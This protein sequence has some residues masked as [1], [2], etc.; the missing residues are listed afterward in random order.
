MNK[1][2]Q[3]F[4]IMLPQ[5]HNKQVITFGNIEIENRKSDCHKYPTAAV[6]IYKMLTSNRVS[7]SEKK[8][9]HFIGY[10]DDYCKI[11]TFSIMLPQMI[12]YVKSYDDESKWMLILT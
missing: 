4:G 5:K 3:T 8:Y 7:P 2:V 9:K 10:K 11:K 1:Q 12:A 6:D